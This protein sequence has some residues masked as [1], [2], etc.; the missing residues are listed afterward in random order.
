M[1][2]AVNIDVLD[3]VLDRLKNVSRHGDYWIASCPARDDRTPSMTIRRGEKGVLLHDFGGSTFGE[4]VAALGMDEGSLFFDDTEARK[5]WLDR[6][7]K[8]KKEKQYKTPEVPEDA[9]FR[10]GTVLWMAKRAISEETLRHFR[11]YS[12]SKHY[13]PA[14]V[15]GESAAICFPYYADDTVK[16]VKYRSV[17]K[18]V[19]GREVK[20]FTMS[21]GAQ[22]IWYNLDGVDESSG[23]V[24]IVEGEMDVLAMHEAGI[25]NVVSPPNGC[26]SIGEEVMLSGER[27]L[28]DDRVRIILAGD[29][30]APGQKAMDDFA[31]RIGKERCAKVAWP[32]DCKDANETLVV[33]GA[34]RVRECMADARPYPVEAI[35]RVSDVADAVMQL[36]HE[37]LPRGLSTGIPT[38]DSVYTIKTGYFSVVTGSPGSGKTNLI[39]MIATNL[40]EISGIHSGIC[41]LENKEVARHIVNILP[42]HAR[43]PFADGRTQRMTEEEAR[44]GMRWMNEYI[45]FVQPDVPSL[46]EI[47]KAMRSMVYYQGVKLIVIDPWNRLAHPSQGLSDIDHIAR[48]LDA[49]GNFAHRFDVHPILVAHPTKL[50]K[51]SKGQ[52]PVPTLYDIAGAAH[53]YNMAD[54]GW[55]LWRDRVNWHDPIEFHL[56]KSR[57][58]EIAT[59]GCVKIGY[60]PATTRYYDLHADGSNDTTMWKPPTLI[61]EA[62]EDRYAADHQRA[63]VEDEG[64]MKRFDP[65]DPEDII[66]MD[67][68]M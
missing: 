65:N 1:G 47:L 54:F 31:A 37:G 20:D 66:F 46:D 40:A 64:E 3:E 32:A 14:R 6:L 43:L 49:I 12:E 33:H 67:G 21:S 62:Y 55:S 16:N 58:E 18:I 17:G 59:L 38:L 27:F 22:P 24:V 8:P 42:K 10:E 53:F 23:E 11:V 25:G 57:R 41:S 35:V 63:I 15:K 36:Y 34:E 39:D 51:D 45:E 30:D 19:E 5:S 61:D 7:P 9:S 2:M 48:C 29:M 4:I 68:T 44:E 52:Y 56:M 26:E 13:F 60:D 28:S 50:V